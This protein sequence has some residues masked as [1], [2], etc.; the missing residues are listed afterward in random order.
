[1]SLAC[2]HAIISEV[3]LSLYGAGGLHMR[4]VPGPKKCGEVKSRGSSRR[5]PWTTKRLKRTEDRKFLLL[6]V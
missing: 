4:A 2:I 5:E 3:H 6:L 1:M